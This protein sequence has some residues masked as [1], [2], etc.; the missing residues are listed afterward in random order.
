LPRQK[1]YTE[2]FLTRLTKE[3][4]AVLRCFAKAEGVSL[5]RLLVESALTSQRPSR[6]MI[7]LRQQ[8]IFHVRRTGQNLSQILESL[9]WD[10]GRGV[11]NYTELAEALRSVSEA[12]KA[13]G[14]AWHKVAREDRSNE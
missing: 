11:D 5:S 8:A 14:T 12:L 9:R 1:H 6:E 4:L 10:F 7:L 13:L 2:E 3:E